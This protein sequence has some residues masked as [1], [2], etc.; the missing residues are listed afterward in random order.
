LTLSDHDVALGQVR[1]IMRVPDM[2]D[3]AE[4]TKSVRHPMV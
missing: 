3:P 2:L 4:P 1:G